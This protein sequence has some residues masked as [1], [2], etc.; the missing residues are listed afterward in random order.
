[1]NP[2]I[3][4]YNNSQTQPDKEICNLLA[5]EIS[6]LLPNDQSKVWHKHPV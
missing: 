1:M 5:Q 4:A 2:D 3:Q 6:K